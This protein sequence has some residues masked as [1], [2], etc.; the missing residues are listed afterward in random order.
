MKY[1][2]LLNVDSEGV[3]EKLI[4]F[5]IVDVDGNA[6]VYE[7]GN[8]VKIDGKSCKTPDAVFAALSSGAQKSVAYDAVNYPYAQPVAYALNSQGYLG[9]I[10]TAYQGEGEDAE[11]SFSL[12]LSGAYTYNGYA[13]GIY[14]TTWE[15]LATYGTA[16]VFGIPENDRTDFDKYRAY[17]MEASES[18]TKVDVFNID[19]ESKL[20]KTV[21]LY[22]DFTT[23]SYNYTDPM[24]LVK[25]ISIELDAEGETVYAVTCIYMQKNLEE[26]H[27]MEPKVAAD[28]GVGDV[29]RMLKNTKDKIYTKEILFDKSEP[30]TFANRVIPYR[31][32]SKYDGP[33]SYGY[34]FVYGTPILI[35]D[36]YMRMTK[37]IVSDSDFAVTNTPDNVPMGSAT[38]YEYSTVRGIPT[39]EAATQNDIRTYDMYPDDAS[40]VL[41]FV[42]SNN[43]NFVLIINE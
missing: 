1:G 24:Y 12:D 11:N 38:I 29:F 34:K 23:E 10:D 25:D 15:N 30:L 35:K 17:S 36:G 41:L 39:V 26:V 5:I 20:A 27:V 40:E 16:T 9:K 6:T 4:R 2:Y 22:K 18:G 33:L 8:S 28:L 42:Y 32:T 37:S 19:E 14:S 3:I 31:G 43:V 21:F 7:M 13:N